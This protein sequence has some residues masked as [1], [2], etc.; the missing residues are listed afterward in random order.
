[1][2]NKYQY[3]IL[4]VFLLIGSSL[5]ANILAVTTLASPSHH[6]WH[7][8]YFLGLVEKKHNIT[9]LGHDEEKDK[10]DNFTVLTLEGTF[11]N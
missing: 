5:S 11:L 9:V 1:M 7:K 2:F 8:A 4:Y 10:V 3:V 6:I